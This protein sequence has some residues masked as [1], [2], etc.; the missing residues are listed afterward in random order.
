MN[1][2]MGRVFT[3]TIRIVKSTSG[4]IAVGVVDR[5]KQKE[6]Q[7]SYRSGNAVCYGTHREKGQIGYGEGGEF[8]WKDTDDRLK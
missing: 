5:E 3:F 1:V 8:K 2:V 7:S 6:A 4:Q